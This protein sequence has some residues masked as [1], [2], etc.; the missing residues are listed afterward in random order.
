MKRKKQKASDDT[1]A[2]GTLCQKETF[3]FLLP[4]Q[5]SRL[6]LDRLLPVLL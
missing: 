2:Q 1:E 5:A 4:S 3:I 6:L